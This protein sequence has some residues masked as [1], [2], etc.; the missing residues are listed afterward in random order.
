MWEAHT[1]LYQFQ[2][3][4]DSSKSNG[5]NDPLMNDFEICLELPDLANE[6]QEG[7]LNFNFR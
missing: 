1:I 3:S 2:H 7:L 6:T 5:D 4:C